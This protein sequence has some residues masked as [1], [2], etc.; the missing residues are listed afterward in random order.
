MPG[1]LQ[2]VTY[3]NPL[4]YFMV[5]VKGI[6]LKNLPVAEVWAQTWPL[7][8]IAAVTLGLA[9]WLFRRRME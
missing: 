8:I 1:W 2:V 7:L 5:V 3:G 4:R 6:F 9:T